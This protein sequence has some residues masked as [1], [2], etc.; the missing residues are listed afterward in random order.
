MPSAERAL[1]VL[2]AA[3]PELIGGSADLT[4]SNN[5]KTSNQQPVTSNHFNGRYIYYGVREH[6]MAAVMNG[7]SLHGGFIPYG[8]TFL[9][10]SD[11]CRPAIR[12]SA[13]MK[14]R[15]IYV[16]THDSIGL[17]EDGPTHQPVE[18]LASLRAIP[19][20]HVYRPCDAMETAECWEAAMI[21]PFSPSLLALSRQNLPTL[22]EAYTEQNLCLRGA[23]ILRDC[24]GTPQVTLIATGSEVAIAVEAQKLL[25]EKNITAR[26]VSMPCWYMFD[27]QPDA[28]RNQVIE[29]SSLKVAIEA[30][31]GFG[32]EKYIGAD[33]IFVGM[34][35]FGASAPA[36]DLYKHF[37][38]TAENVVNT[39]TEKLK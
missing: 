25:A 1:E 27:G 16:M 21:H 20:L 33:G 28:Y 18:H 38:I 4:G 5:T 3:I 29:P 34:Q 37:G 2:T 17:G 39:V 7:L 32:W 9:V 11:Y 30:A 22:R 13:L 14:Q 36:K 19:G 23:Y 24:K 8:G 35:G 31:S 12:L 6:A 15:V 26:V 10:F